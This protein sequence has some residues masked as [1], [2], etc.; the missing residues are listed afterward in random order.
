VLEAPSEAP[1]RLDLNNE[2]DASFVAQMH[3]IIGS[4]FSEQL[5]HDAA[6]ARRII[7]P[8]SAA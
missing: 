2:A 6:W 4:F 3:E 8:E 1:V 7:N 5:M